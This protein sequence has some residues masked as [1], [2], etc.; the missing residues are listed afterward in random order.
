MLAYEKD[1]ETGIVR[2]LDDQCI[3]CKYCEMKCPYGVPKY[4]VRL[5]I[6]RK[7]DM[8][9]NRLMADEAPACVQACPSEAISIRIVGTDEVPSSGSIVPGAFESS[10]TRPTTRFVGWTEEEGL[11]PAGAGEPRLAHAHLPLV[12]MLVLTQAAV[13]ISLAAQLTS[14][15]ALGVLAKNV[16][17][18]ERFDWWHGA[19]R[20]WERLPSIFSSCRLLEVPRY[21]LFSHGLWSGSPGQD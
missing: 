17:W 18:M 12:L 13:G 20:R 5:G 3:G 10:Y 21:P 14:S 9:Y 1:R 7:C 16:S 4:S 8:C 2:H 6:V 15:T 11:A 19:E